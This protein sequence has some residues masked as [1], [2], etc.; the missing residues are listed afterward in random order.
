[1]HKRLEVKQYL[2]KANWASASEQAL[3]IEGRLARPCAAVDWLGLA[4]NP[5]RC[6]GARVLSAVARCTEPQLLSK[7]FPSK[8]DLRGLALP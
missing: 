3:P 4:L 8:A 2:V 7:P 5:S 6:P 1:V